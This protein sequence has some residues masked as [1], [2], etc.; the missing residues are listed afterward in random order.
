[1]PDAII[2]LDVSAPWEP[3]ERPGA[4]VARRRRSRWRGLAGAAVLGLVAV[5]PGGADL[6][7]G[8]DPLY[9]ADFQVLALDAAGGRIIVY[10]YQSAGADPLTE[11]LD[12]RTGALLWRRPGEADESYAAFT[13]RA[14]FVQVE[15]ADADGAYTG[16]VSAYDAGT[17]R[18]LWRRDMVRFTGLAGGLLVVQEQAWPD[19]DDGFDDSYGNPDDSSVALPRLPH[20]ERYLGLDQLTGALRWTAELAPGTESGFDTSGYPGLDGLRELDRDGTLRI[21]DLRTGEVTGRYHLDFSGAIS[22]HQAGLPGQEV[23]LAAG[24][25]G[26]DVFD[27]ASGRRLWRWSGEAP[28][29]NGPVPCLRVHYCVFGDS[30]TDVLDAATGAVLWRAR[31]YTALLSDTGDRLLMYRQI[32]D[33]YHPDQVTAFAVDGDG[34]VAW[35]RRGWYVANG[36]FVAGRSPGFFLW[37]PISNTD[38]IIGRLDPED[39]SVRVIGRAPD[40]YGSPQCTATADRVA[41]LAIGVLYVWPLR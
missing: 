11:A 29:W 3:P 30:G 41:C 36:Y 16:H 34:A 24:R 26:S 40:F 18:D 13:D 9:S 14:A 8:L 15:R 27:L 22:R 25:N 4:A 38:A 5:L 28:A 21:R 20:H 35:D 31:G 10:R 39:G 33:E 6:R 23:V 2:E 17:G 32:S 7:P 37:R 19:E 1:M 12:A